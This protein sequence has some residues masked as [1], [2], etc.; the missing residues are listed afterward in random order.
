MPSQALYYPGIDIRDEAW[1]KTSLLYWDSIRTIVPESVNTPYSTETGLALQDAGFLVPLRVHSGMEE[2]KELA[3]DALIYLNTSEGVELLVLGTG[4]R[5]TQIHV[6][7]LP[8]EIRHIASTLGSWSSRGA[9]WLQVDDDFGL[10]YITLLATRLA[11]RVG[12][13]LLTPLRMA[14][15]LAV[16]ARLDA[17]LNG[18][19]PWS[20]HGPG[21][22]CREYEA[23]PARR[24][25]P[26]GLAPGLLSQ[27]AIQQVVIAPDTPIHRLLHFRKQH[28]DELALFRTKV[29]QL[30][31]VVEADLSAEALRQRV[32]DL[33]TNEVAPALAN[34]KE[35][36]NGHRIRWLSEGLLKITFMSAGPSTMLVAAGLAVP[37]ALLAGAGLSLIVSGTLY[38][39]DK[40]KLLRENPY[41]YLLSLRGEFK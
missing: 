29:E 31:S 32:S 41:A 1:L 39:V 36:L 27:L 18:M 40:K 16:A 22:D 11:E 10:F 19:V 2:I 8:Y 23:F 5:G 7:K 3:D 35:A 25:V 6:E 13:S 33:Y 17:Q 30:T 26:R 20:L 21:Q 37:T 24:R 28:R 34:L 14:E 4:D 12:A 38:N 15:R 9:D